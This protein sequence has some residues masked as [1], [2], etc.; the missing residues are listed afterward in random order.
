MKVSR[1]ALPPTIAQVAQ[2]L[3]SILGDAWLLDILRELG[4]DELRTI[5]CAHI[6]RDDHVARQDLIAELATAAGLDPYLDPAPTPS[7]TP[8]RSPARHCSG[9]YHRRTA[10]R[11][12]KDIDLML[13]LDEAKHRSIRSIDL[14]R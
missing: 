4:R 14:G 6:L 7:P 5:C 2:L 8:A 1:S 13:V 11:P 3:A 10:I 9:S 12:L